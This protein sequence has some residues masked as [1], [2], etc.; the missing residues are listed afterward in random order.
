MYLLEQ[1]YLAK[2]KTGLML[3]RAHLLFVI[4]CV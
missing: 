3:V 2:E 1:M 4:K